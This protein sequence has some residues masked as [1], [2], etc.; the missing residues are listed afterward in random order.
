MTNQKQ[1]SKANKRSND[2]N[3]QV[4]SIPESQSFSQP[5]IKSPRTERKT[6]SKAL[7]KSK[8]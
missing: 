1:K 2:S 6:K 5:K 8:F 3:L 4:Q 7:E